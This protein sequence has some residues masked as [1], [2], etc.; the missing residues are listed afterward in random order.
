MAIY[1]LHQTY[2]QLSGSVFLAT[3]QT[4]LYRNIGL[5]MMMIGLPITYFLIATPSQGGMGIGAT[6]LAVKMVV[7]NIV[8]VNIQLY[9]NARYLG[10]SFGSYLRHQIVS[11]A[12][13]FAMAFISVFAVERILGYETSIIVFLLSGVL[14]TVLAVMSAYR[15]PA[16]F[17]LQKDDIRSFVQFF[18]ERL[19]GGR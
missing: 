15:F 7:V 2:G 4:V 5:I 3:G 11:A 16:V 17:G 14:Y 12:C 9:F 6:G 19:S 10:F 8:W 13:L 1:P 18:R